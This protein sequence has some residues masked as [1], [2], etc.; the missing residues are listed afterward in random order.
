MRTSCGAGACLAAG[1]PAAGGEEHRRSGCY[2]HPVG[3]MPMTVPVRS[4]VM[5]RL[6]ATC[7]P[8]IGRFS[9][10]AHLSRRSVH[11]MPISVPMFDLQRTVQQNDAMLAVL[12]RQN[13]LLQYIAES[14]HRIE[15]GQAAASNGNHS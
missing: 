5:H 3:L 4:L 9:G 10:E 11:G 14:L 6:G 7:R 15:V 13:E 1:A 12:A 2:R 8:R